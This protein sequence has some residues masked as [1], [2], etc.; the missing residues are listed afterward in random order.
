MIKLKQFRN[1]ISLNADNLVLRGCSLRNTDWVYGA[2]VYSGH[3]TK[4][5][6]N[7]ANSKYK[8]SK[9]EKKTTASI[10]GIFGL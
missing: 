4:V 2:V 6:Q 5:M 1:N 8:F 7:S 10:I 3:D 9:L